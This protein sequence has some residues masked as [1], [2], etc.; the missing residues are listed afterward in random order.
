MAISSLTKKR[1]KK[2]AER[3]MSV[4][5]YDQEKEIVKREK[6]EALKKRERE[7]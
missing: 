4:W 5:F 7:Y 2:Q 1:R 3:Q 6:C